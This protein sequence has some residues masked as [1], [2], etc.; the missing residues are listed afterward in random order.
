MILETQEQPE[1]QVQQVQ[2]GLKEIPEPKVIQA[3]VVMKK[4]DGNCQ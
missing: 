3:L 2:L 4:L 1:I